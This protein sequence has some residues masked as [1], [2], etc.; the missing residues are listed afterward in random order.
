MGYLALCALL[1][2]GIV[3][4]VSRGATIS[5]SYRAPV[6]PSAGETVPEAVSDPGRP[7]PRGA[8]PRARVFLSEVQ[9]YRGGSGGDD[10]PR[11]EDR[12]QHAGAITTRRGSGS[13]RRIP[14][15]EW[16]SAATAITSSSP[17]S[18][19]ASK[20]SHRLPPHNIYIQA[21]AE[22]GLVGF[23]VLCWWIL[24]SAYNYWVAERKSD[25]DPQGRLYLR[26]C[27]AITLFTLVASLTSGNLVRTPLAMVI[28]LSA[29]CRQVQREGRAGSDGRGRGG[30][31]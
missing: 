15:W 14:C 16:G 28:A 22:T 26:L 5:F 2:A 10:L 9:Q 25:D 24:Q 7:D 31:A 27:E 6:H 18:I 17:N 12:A 23:L 4:S 29:V 8:S 11:G 19:P 13:G 1:S 3:T 30:E 21:L 20:A